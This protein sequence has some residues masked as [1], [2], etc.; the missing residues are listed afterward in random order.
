MAAIILKGIC[1][2]DILDGT[3][4]RV[5]FKLDGVQDT[6]STII[7]AIASVPKDIYENIHSF[8]LRKHLDS[9]TLIQPFVNEGFL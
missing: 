2:L 5:I 7:I 8:I 1:S 9:R 6:H 3:Y 4:R